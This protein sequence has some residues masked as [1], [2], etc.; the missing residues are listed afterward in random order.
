MKID[1][2]SALSQPVRAR[3][4]KANRAFSASLSERASAPA[5]AADASPSAALGAL[6]ALQSGAGDDGRAHIAAQQTLTLL[7]QLQRDILKE[8][9]LTSSLEALGAAAQQLS[10]RAKSAAMAELCDAIE[11]R[12]RVELAK[13][14]L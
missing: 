1:R 13:R 6:I 12:A 7:E 4:K 11:L 14:G 9:P 8:A 3:A 2:T 5:R 10:A